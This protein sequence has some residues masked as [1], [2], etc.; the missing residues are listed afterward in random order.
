[1]ADVARTLGESQQNFSAAL[2]KDDIKTGLLEKIAE[3]SGIPVQVFFSG[4][5]GSVVGDTNVVNNGHD[6]TTADPG[7]VAVIQEQQAQMGRLIAV[8]ENLTGHAK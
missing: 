3:A 7:L 2:M 4:S 8:I 1:M 5:S 6:Q